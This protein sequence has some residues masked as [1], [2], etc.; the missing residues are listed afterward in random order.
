[1]I[2]C[3]LLSFIVAYY[4]LSV[5]TISIFIIALLLLVLS[6]IIIAYYYYLL[7]STIAYYYYLLSLLPTTKGTHQQIQLQLKENIKQSNYN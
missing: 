7:L 3:Y 2:Y 6:I 5:F 4:D 1:M